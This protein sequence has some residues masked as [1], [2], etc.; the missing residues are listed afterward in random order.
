M[1]DKLHKDFTSADGLHYL[2]AWRVATLEARDEL[3]AYAE[4]VGKVARVDTP[5]SWWLLVSIGT[6]RRLDLK[7][8]DDE[9]TDVQAGVT[10]ETEGGTES[11]GYAFAGVSD[12]PARC[13]HVHGVVTG[14][15]VSIGTA[16]A[17]GV[18]DALA[19]ADHV[20][21]G[22][23]LLTL[24]DASQVQAYSEVSGEL[25][26]TY[27]GV[28]WSGEALEAARADHVH[29][30]YVGDPV[31]VG[32]ANAQGTS[33]ALARAD[34]V[35]DA[36]AKADVAYTPNTQ[37]GTT[38]T[39]AAT[40]SARLVKFTNAGAIALTVPANAT[41]AL[42]LGTTIAL[43]QAGTGQITVAGGGGV[44]LRNPGLTLKSR[45]QWSRMTLEK[46][47]ADEWLLSG[48]LATV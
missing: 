8:C 18:S 47:G 29:S 25:G 32:T 28:G 22:T 13:D 10:I 45:Q 3:E 30:V 24:A 1:V 26:P 15:P 42:P 40:D 36:S 34:H 46:I 12:E 5:L 19:R 43:V 6:W 48:D 4:D 14:D 16:N 17:L 11:Y 37:N 31:A 21:D 27:T 38:Y 20:H 23:A 41:V 2:Q 35:H 44:G 7:L 39:L 33:A 9:P